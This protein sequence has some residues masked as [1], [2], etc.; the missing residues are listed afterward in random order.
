MKPEFPV[1]LTIDEVAGI[2]RTS[3]EAIT[4]ELK[5]GRLP[6][7]KVGGEWRIVKEELFKFM[8]I[9]MGYNNGT[10]SCINENSLEVEWRKV[11]S[12][13]YIWPV[14]K[15]KTPDDSREIYNEAYEADI[16]LPGC[17]IV[18]IGYTTRETAGM[19]DR[20]RIVVFM[21]FGSQLIPVVE[22]AG[23]N[24]FEKTHRVASVIKND[25]NKQVSS[26]SQLPPEY[27][28][29]PIDTY[30][31]VVTGP[32]ASHGLAVVIDKDDRRTML[33]HA[34]IRAHFKRWI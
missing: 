18:K 21:K 20:Y 9:D 33:H 10:I 32:Y 8:E 28:E 17:S 23:A 7:F 15:G 19:D 3:T 5:K 34:L 24:D 11:D 26:L 2:L 6:G 16:D 27:Q 14:E 25:D 31:D 29:F 12:F 13:D 4:D 1:V 22:F 30:S